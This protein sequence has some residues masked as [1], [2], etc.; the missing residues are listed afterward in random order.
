MSFS[1][2]RSVRYSRGRLD[3]RTSRR[4]AASTV[5]FS[6][7][8][9]SS[10]AAAIS[11]RNASRNGLSRCWPLGLAICSSNLF[12]ILLICNSFQFRDLLGGE[13]ALDALETQKQPRRI[14]PCSD[15]LD[16]SFPFPHAG[17]SLPAAFPRLSDLVEIFAHEKPRFV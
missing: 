4:R 16:F 13:M 14:H 11:I 8:G 5:T 2:S 10:P 3:R 6:A 7:V 12:I 1:I 15:P 17:L 9:A